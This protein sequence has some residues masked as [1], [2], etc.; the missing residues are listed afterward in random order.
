MAR[1]ATTR[2][3]IITTAV[4]WGIGLLIFFPILWTILTSFKT[5]A[6]AIAI[7]ADALS[8]DLEFYAFSRRLEA[9]ADVDEANSAIGVVLALGGLPE[10]IADV[11]V[12]ESQRQ[13]ISFDAFFANSGSGKMLRT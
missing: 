3:K 10:P 6:E 2:R 1:A 12:D 8:E 4:A 13:H 11:L 9:Y 5:E 7:Y